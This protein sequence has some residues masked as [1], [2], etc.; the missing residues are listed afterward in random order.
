MK[1]FILITAVW[2][3]LL[4]P[5]CG[6]LFAAP[7]ASQKVKNKISR[8][9]KEFK[10]MRKDSSSGFSSA[11]MNLSSDDLK[12]LANEEENK[13]KNLSALIDQTPPEQLPAKL[14]ELYVNEHNDPGKYPMLE[15]YIL[16][17]GENAVSPL[18]AQYDL[19]V[20]SGTREKVLLMLGSL[21]SKSA[22]EVVRKALDDPKPR[23]ALTAQTALRL[24]LKE[25]A[26]PEL[27]QRLLPSN[28]SWALKHTLREI[29][30]TGGDNWCSDFFKVIHTHKVN[31]RDLSLIGDPKECPES[32]IGYY[33]ENLVSTLLMDENPVIYGADVVSLAEFLPVIL[34]KDTSNALV[35][36]VRSNIDP[37]S[38]GLLGMATDATELTG[39]H[40]DIILAALNK[41][42]D[43]LLLY[44]ERA[45]SVR[46]KNPDL[47]ALLN[48]LIAR[49]IFIKTANGAL[50]I[51]E[52]LPTVEQ[53]AIK[54]FN[55]G[56]LKQEFPQ[57]FS[58][59]RFNS[60]K[61][62]VARQLILRLSN[63]EYIRRIEPLLTGILCERFGWKGV[64]EGF[65]SNISKPIGA[66]VGFNEREADGLL[67]KI[68]ANLSADDIRLH[69]KKN[70]NNFLTEWYLKDLLGRKGGEPFDAKGRSFSFKIEAV[71]PSGYV[72]ASSV[73]ELEYGKEQNI[74]LPS[75]SSDYPSH[76]IKLKLGLDPATR[77]F[78]IDPILIDL[79]PHA[80][81][82]GIYVPVG[83]I[84]ET[85]LIEPLAGKKQTIKWR[86]E[87]MAFIAESPAG[88]E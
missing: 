75:T 3:I 82:F 30:L 18:A 1:K 57:V 19:S 2:M 5:A 8:D 74:V 65:S 81:G 61:R 17:L 88:N 86:F 52:P 54:W 31:L 21:Q 80:S 66:W 9:L 29:E 35:D 47:E 55:I 68:G 23:V 16:L 70:L 20:P 12:K 14:A 36:A 39:E 46:I 40:E 58:K 76:T 25:Q 10:Q 83:G 24:I 15:P 63:P 41:A 78:R 69:L 48:H 34:S 4:G 43:N 42:K 71:D 11:A 84:N 13:L 28:S 45:S 22:L 60:G 53:I 62:A 67:K 59:E 50:Q 7:S 32:V 87:H 51:K 79:K 73:F 26:R 33:A 37:Q 44:P 85:S 72:L 49:K 27:E 38:M 6:P 56:I 77:F 64:V